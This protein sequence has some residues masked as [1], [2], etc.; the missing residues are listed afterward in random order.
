MSPPKRTADS[1]EELRASLVAHAQRIVTRDGP[2]ALT[3]RALAAEAG[4]A[5]G[6]PYKVFSDRHD[7]VAAV[8]RAEF[9]RLQTAGRDLV[10]RAGDGT[11]GANLAWFAELLLDSPAVALAP[12]VFADEALAEA[13]NETVQETG[14]GPSMFETAYAA[15]L[16]AEKDAGRV[17]SDTDEQAFAFLLAGA[18]HNLVVSGEAYPTPHRRQLRR[19]LKATAAAISPDPDRK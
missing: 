11:V 18:I 2:V 4:C 16:A 9:T 1:T 13:F 14:V 7:L 6:L 19:Y 12:E 3:M 15:Y 8:L 17:R 5:V 10:S